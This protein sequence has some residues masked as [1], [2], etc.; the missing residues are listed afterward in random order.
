MTRAPDVSDTSPSIGQDPLS[1]EQ[2]KQYREKLEKRKEKT[3]AGD[4][5]G[6][7]RPRPPGPNNR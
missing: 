4:L 2:L 3:G 6:S 7:M 1:S 5:G